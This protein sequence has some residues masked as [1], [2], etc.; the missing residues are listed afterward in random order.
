MPIGF[1]LTPDQREL[2]TLA[3]KFAREEMAP[4]ASECDKK[5]LFPEDIY[6]RA[7]DLGLMNLNVPTEYGGSGLALLDQCIIT[8]ELASACGGMTTSILAN[9]LAIQ[10]INLGGSPE[11]KERLLKPLCSSYHLASFGLTEPSGGSDAA[12]LKTR[13]ER[14]GDHYVLNGQKCFITNA[15]QASLFTIFATVDPAKRDKGICA[16]VVPRD[17][18]GLSIGKEE[19][20]M[21]Q[22]ASSTATV[23]MEDVKVPLEN[24]L[25]KEG[26]G[27]RI[28][29][30]TLDSTR[31]PI[32]ALAVGIARAAL[33]QA[34]KYS[35]QRTSFGKKIAEH[36]SIAAKI[37]NMTIELEASRLLTWRAA[38]LVDQGHRASLESS[39]A[40]CFSSDAAMRICDEAIQIFGGYGYMRDYPVEK[41]LRDAKLC[42]IY[43]GA[44]EIQRQV[45]AREFLKRFA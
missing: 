27:F 14:R 43:E 33:E 24:M 5:A 6:R 16:F 21:G 44:N 15:P 38:W 20:K 31:T 34:S 37:A 41:Y 35:L 40:K 4:R 42:Q 36:Q 22:R 17:T 23:I 29:M 19:D 28:A 18:P 8:E 9:C 11:Q 30:Q 45:I 10:P 39:I 1:E 13:A 3:S 32:G 7:F 2:Q 25:G 12:A 26:E